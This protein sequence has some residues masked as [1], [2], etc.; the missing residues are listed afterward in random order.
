MSDRYN[1]YTIKEIPP[2][3]SPIPF[4]RLERVDL[5][6]LFKDVP[7]DKHY[8]IIMKN[9]DR[10]I[11]SLDPTNKEKREIK[12]W[13][14]DDVGKILEKNLKD[15]NGSFFN[16]LGITKPFKKGYKFSLERVEH[17]GSMG[18]TYDK[19]PSILVI[20]YY[21]DFLDY[22]ERVAENERKKMYNMRREQEIYDY[23]NKIKKRQE[24]YAKWYEDTYHTKLD[25]NRIKKAYKNNKNGGFMSVKD[26]D[27]RTIRSVFTL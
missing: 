19:D 24:A 18:S 16:W 13:V 1:V 11:L 3:S 26:I 14:G 17:E 9:F 22:E 7:K 20:S 12:I 2:P 6:L 4:E 5:E 8:N 27:D 23:K 15:I 10:E 21:L 25:K